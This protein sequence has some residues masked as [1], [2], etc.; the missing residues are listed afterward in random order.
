MKPFKKNN[1]IIISEIGLNHNGKINLAKKM[2]D[3]ASKA[4][5]DIIKFQVAIPEE[6]KLPNAP[7]ANY[8]KK[9]IKIKT[10]SLELSKKLHLKFS[11]IIQIQKYIRKKNKL[12]LASA[13]DLISLKFLK[14]I[15]CKS[16]KIPSGEIN[17]Y[18][19]LEYCSKNFKT[20]FLSTGMS[21]IEDI[22]N[23]IKILKK[24]K[25]N[26]KIY[27]M[28]CNTQYPSPVGDINLNA[29]INIGKKFNLPY[30]LSDHSLGIECSLAAVAMGASVIEKHFTLNKK[31][32][33]P[34]H[35][36]SIMPKEL[37]NLCTSARNIEKAL[38]DGKKKISKSELQNKK[39]VR[40]GVYF[41]KDIKKNQK[42]Q[43]K[44]LG[45]LRPENNFSPY[46]IKKVVGNKTKKDV[47]KF[48]SVNKNLLN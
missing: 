7:F 9:N 39:I 38:G 24:S 33:G 2:I 22:R 29:M 16:I 41:L 46:L 6:V 34:D 19:Y 14:T 21:N 32:F 17:N 11:E 42:I 12:F 3:L 40:K 43:L 27:V 47:K 37:E 31:M 8:Q 20:I 10:S 35:I 23:A 5:V 26:K 30:G 4:G 25:K 45:I 44:D 13:F 48:Q 15:G 18:L 28:Q 36:S 1:V